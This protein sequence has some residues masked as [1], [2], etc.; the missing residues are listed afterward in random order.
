MASED[1]KQREGLL[2]PT[3]RDPGEHVSLLVPDR[4]TSNVGVGPDEPDF[5]GVGLMGFDG[6]GGVVV[7]VV[8]EEGFEL[9]LVDFLLLSLFSLFRRF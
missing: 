9:C 6:G 4:T 8:V 7:I 2:T 3:E 1:E 5:Q